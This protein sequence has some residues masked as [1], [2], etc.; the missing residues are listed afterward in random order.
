[1][2]GGGGVAV[3]SSLSLSA[4]ALDPSLSF[5]RSLW[6]LIRMPTDCARAAGTGARVGTDG[7]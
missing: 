4:R 7:L 3:L 1:M 5:T 2:L 6:V